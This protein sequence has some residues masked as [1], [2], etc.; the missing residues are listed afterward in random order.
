MLS[1]VS[2]YVDG[3]KAVFMELCE[4]N[5]VKRVGSIVLIKC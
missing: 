5:E 2:M 4:S 3:C 1:G